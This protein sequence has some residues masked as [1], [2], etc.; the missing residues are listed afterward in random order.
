MTLLIVIVLAAAFAAVT[1]LISLR[2]HPWRRCLRC[3]G[4]GRTRARVWRGA[5]GSC[6][7]C[8]GK[9]R[10]PRLG[11]R[12]LDPGRAR[13]LTAPRGAHKKADRRQG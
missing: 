4:A 11:I 6:P 10:K 7:R 2:V 13:E 5:F 12:V 8:G 3:K 9:G 1:Y